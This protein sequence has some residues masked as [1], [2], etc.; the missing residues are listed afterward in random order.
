MYLMRNVSPDVMQTYTECFD[1]MIQT[2]LCQYFHLNSTSSAQLDTVQPGSRLDSP[3]VIQL[4]AYQIR[5]SEQRGGLGLK[6]MAKTTIPAYLAATMAHVLSTV[7]LLP[8]N[9]VLFTMNSSS[10]LFTDPVMLVHE[11]F[12]A[13]GAHE[14][15]ADPTNPTNAVLT[16]PSRAA[17][18]DPNPSLLLMRLPSTLHKVTNQKSLTHW[19]Q[20]NDPFLQHVQKISQAD[21]AIRAHINHISQIEISG[22]HD[23]FDIRQTGAL[24]T[25]QMRS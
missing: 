19:Y 12:V 14:V 8:S 2:L 9:A 16:I 18:L 24:L 22:P 4:A 11:R 21:R 10:S 3:Q 17:L 6:S 1:T 23:R 5:D 20:E 25:L 15:T 13:R 7:S